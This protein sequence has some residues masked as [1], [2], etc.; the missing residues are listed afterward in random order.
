MPGYVNPGQTVGIS[1]NLTAPDEQGIY[2][3]FWKLEYPTGSTNPDASST[4]SYAAC[5]DRYTYPIYARASNAD[6][7][8]TP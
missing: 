5:T 1:I 2:E 7:N 3:G 4:D 6:P 8:Q